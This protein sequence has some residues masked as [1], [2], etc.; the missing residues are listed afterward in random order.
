[1]NLPRFWVVFNFVTTKMMMND[2]WKQS[3]NYKVLKSF[4]GDVF[5]S[6]L[7]LIAVWV[8]MVVFVSR[9]C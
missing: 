5:V 2:E 8:L 7:L 4:G 3:V 6:A 1:M 9:C